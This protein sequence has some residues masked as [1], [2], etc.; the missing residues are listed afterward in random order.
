MVFVDRS[1]AL[2]EVPGTLAQE[3]W[4]HGHGPLGKAHRGSAVRP[5]C[6]GRQERQPKLR[7]E[8]CEARLKKSRG[9]A[10]L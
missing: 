3:I 8:K 9:A 5:M 2:G 10:V 6:G 7:E 1:I 4:P